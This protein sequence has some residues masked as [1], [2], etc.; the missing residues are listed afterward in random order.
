[1]P[2]VPPLPIDPLLGDIAGALATF[3]R[4]VL[5]APPGAGKTTRVPTAVLDAGLAGDK[6]IVV[7]EPRR[8][9]ARAAAEFVAGERQ[10][11]VGQEVGYRVRFDQ[12]GSASTRLWFVTEGILGRQLA[13]DPF[14][15]HVGVL[16]LDEFHERH[17]QGD[18]ALAVARELQATVRPDL[19]IVVMSATL[20]TERVA[21]YLG[22]CPVLTSTGRAYPV[23]IT[24]AAAPDERPL[25]A[26]VAAALRNVLGST[27]DDGGDILVFLPG[28]AEIR[29]AATASEDLARA[30][31]CDIVPLHGD[32]PLDAQQRAIRRGPR[33]R[34]VLATNVAETAL[35]VDGVTVVIDSGLARTARF[36]ARRGINALHV[37]P[38]SHAAAVQRAGRAGRAAPGRCVRLWT[39]A[40]DRGR[41]ERETPEVARLEL[42]A[43]VL[44]LRAWGLRD[45]GGFA[46][47]DAPPPAALERADRLLRQLGAVD[48][49]GSV[50]AVGRRM[51][52]RAVPPRLARL[53]VESEAR[54][55]VAEAA[56]LAAL[57]SERDIILEQR[58]FGRS[59]GA[60]ATPW[61]AGP[62]DLL[63][64]RDLFEE[65]ARARF[66]A[67]VCRR[68]GIDSR[69]V[70]AVERARRHLAP[71]ANPPETVADPEPLLR[72]VLAGFADRVVRRRAPGS[73]RGVMVGGTGVILSD[74]S[75]VREADLFV[76]VE[77]DAGSRQPLAEARVR[78]ASAIDRAWLDEMFPEAIADTED[79]VF[80]PGPERVVARRR[81][82]FHDLVIEE[83]T[84]PPRDLHAAGL[85]LAAVARQDP[86][87]AVDLGQRGR[88]LLDRLAFL[89]RCL[90]ELGLA[91]DPQAFLA[92]TV[93]ALCVGCSSFAEVRSADLAAALLGQLTPAQRRALDRE[94]PAAY[95]LP[96]GRRA[97]IVY[98]R[99]RPPTVAARLQELFG[100][101]STPRLGGGRVP[102]VIEILAPNQRP[103]QITDDLASFWRTT[104]AEVRKQLRGRYPKHAWPEDPITAT[105]V[106]P[107]KRQ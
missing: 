43:T 91:P 10:T 4:V 78:V 32:L 79:L 14:L 77:V 98:A 50:T 33:R 60:P 103:V 96:A 38:I 1:M 92:D 69:T 48:A 34:V 93:A 28:A 21:A 97:P 20:E 53:L 84:E 16:I 15:D 30:L 45:V 106:G 7:L 95:A 74:T 12:R 81:T 39:E 87:V 67:S 63:L 23:A 22:D 5:Q 44:E 17:L 66:D 62:S 56:T 83:R 52:A 102:L 72:C 80:Q 61:P 75:V 94:A 105:P 76:A 101:T 13:R 58:T 8:I 31:S 37:T 54:Q 46:W 3:G 70:R 11:A 99:D 85:V 29:K 86:A 51:L 6:Q 19:R 88:T 55:C 42:S 18:V 41:R 36:D 49:E 27:G 107:R 68:L 2:P 71:R 25:S 47:L 100:L 9:A 73:S 26:R 40:D 35:T 82:C 59:G 104:Y 89:A 24:H 65:A 90:P 64:R 57:A